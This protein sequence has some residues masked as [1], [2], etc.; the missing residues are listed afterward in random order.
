MVFEVKVKFL[1]TGTLK[2]TIECKDGFTAIQK[3]MGKLN[4]TEKDNISAILIT[5]VI[6]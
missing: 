1:H 5:D 4:A 3:A 2:T 6:H